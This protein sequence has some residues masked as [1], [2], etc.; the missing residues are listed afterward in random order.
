MK[1]KKEGMKFGLMLLLGLFLINLVSASC[2]LDVELVNQDPYPALPGDYVE[3]VFQVDG[4]DNPE[5]DGAVF[6]LV[7]SYPFS[8]DG[9]DAKRSLAG[10]TYISNYKTEWV[11]PYKVRVD[12]DAFGG[13]YEV[14]VNYG[15]RDISLSNFINV[16]V[17][18]SRTDFDSVIQEVS[19]S[20]VSIAL[21][22]TGKNTANSIIVKIPEQENFKVIGT[23]GQMVGNL[24]SGD[25]TLV[26]FDVMSS[27]SG[28]NTFKI[29]I[30][31]TDGLGER[32][33]VNSELQLKMVD[34]VVNGNVVPGS[35]GS[36][37]S[38]PDEGVNWMFWVIIIVIF[39]IVFILYR[40]YFEQIREFFSDLGNGGKKSLKK[41]SNEVPD[42]VKAVSKKRRK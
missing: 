22:N 26:G 38:Q 42:W 33:I 36:S 37:V 24:D 32:R 23:D 19:G 15:D 11:I 7:P 30:H 28:D 2:D 41:D 1:N 34:S 31:Y 21:A 10:S 9:S 18:D 5:C 20:E 27:K 12:E 6:E 13:D 40:K 14:K 25:Y 35:K 17:E 16:S 4:I 8:L 3:L 29:D 39:G